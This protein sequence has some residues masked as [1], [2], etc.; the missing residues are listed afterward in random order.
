MRA[1]IY[2]LITFAVA[3]GFSGVVWSRDLTGQ[4]D[5]KIEDKNHYLVTALVIE[6]TEHEARSC[7]GGKWLRLN[8]VS[9][10]TEDSQFFPVSDALSYG[11]EKSQL[12]IGRNEICDGYL[13]LRGTLDNGIIRG[14]YFSFGWGRKS[15]GFFS[16]SKKK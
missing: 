3:L 10:T 1:A 7:I 5:L 4:W 11:V 8:V 12:T 9:S 14:E 16:L 13:W 6:F 15:L 2:R